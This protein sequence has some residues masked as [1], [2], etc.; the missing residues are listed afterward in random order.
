MI[1]TTTTSK[2]QACSGLDQ[3]G[4]GVL[5]EVQGSR[6]KLSSTIILLTDYHF[7]HLKDFL[8]RDVV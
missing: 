2:K 8:L 3:A 7:R 4:P 1:L 5:V 6:S